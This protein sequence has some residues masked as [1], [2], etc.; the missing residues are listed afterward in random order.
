MP[1]VLRA[2]QVLKSVTVAVD[3]ADSQAIPVGD[4]TS[5]T[6]AIPTG[7]SITSLTCHVS[8]EEGGTY[9]PLYDSLKAAVA[10][11]SLTAGRAYQLP[12][13]TFAVRWLKLVGDAAGTVDVTMKG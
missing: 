9:L 12:F 1:P 5:F 11:T 7:S 3:V 4:F 6:A 10:L 2:C 13:G 8:T